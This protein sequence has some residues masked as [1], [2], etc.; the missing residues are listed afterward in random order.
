MADQ[1]TTLPDELYVYRFFCQG[2]QL[3]FL[4]PARTVQE[5]WDLTRRAEMVKGYEHHKDGSYGDICVRSSAIVAIDQPMGTMPMQPNREERRRDAVPPEP[6]T[7]T[8][9]QTVKKG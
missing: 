8:A 4:S 3:V 9:G 6:K 1:K 5:M 2:A 7:P